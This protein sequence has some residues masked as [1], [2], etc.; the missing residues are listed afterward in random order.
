[1]MVMIM[2]FGVTCGTGTAY[3][4]GASVITPFLVG[5]RVARSLVFCVQC[6]VDLR[7]L[8]LWSICSVCCGYQ[9]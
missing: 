8:G 5:F 3:P 9:L 1:M 2:V 6:F 7:G 4:S